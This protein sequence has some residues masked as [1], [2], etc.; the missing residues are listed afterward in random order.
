MIAQGVSGMF[1]VLFTIAFNEVVITWSM[2][3]ANAD[4]ILT[5]PVTVEA[6]WRDVQGVSACNI[7]T[8]FEDK[9]TFFY[10]RALAII[11]EPTR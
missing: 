7:Q 9:M 5:D 8:G 10:I 1:G 4:G 2:T 11:L 6:S 3:A